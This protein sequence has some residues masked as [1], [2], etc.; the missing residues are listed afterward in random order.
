[1]KK[2]YNIN[3]RR[4]GGK[5]KRYLYYK[6]TLT[7]FRYNLTNLVLQIDMKIKILI[8]CSYTLIYEIHSYPAAWEVRAFGS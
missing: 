3:Q 8:V 2:T 4:S 1:M 5:K 7:I 6:V